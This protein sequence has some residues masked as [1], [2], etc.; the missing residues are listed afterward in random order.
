HG[1]QSVAEAFTQTIRRVG[2]EVRRGARVS[3]LVFQGGRVAG[4]R[5]GDEEIRARTVIS[6]IGARETYRLLVPPERRPRHADSIMALKSS[7][8]IF[9]LYM[10]LDRNVLQ[11]FGLT[12]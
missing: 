4:V 8:S 1:S 5:L 9:T 2:G 3:S 10:A 11:R 6:G 12:G 7:S